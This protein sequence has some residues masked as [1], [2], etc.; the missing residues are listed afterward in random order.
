MKLEWKGWSPSGSL[1]W[2]QGDCDNDSH[3]EGDLKCFHDTVPPGCSGTAASN[4]ADY[5][6]S[7]QIRI[8]SSSVEFGPDIPPDTDIPTALSNPDMS[9]DWSEWFRY[10]HDEILSILCFFVI[11]LCGLNLCVLMAKRKK[12]HY[13]LVK[14]V[15]SAEESDL[16]TEA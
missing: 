10:F 12:R 6:G 16:E 1:G 15:E 13:I 7:D 14:F 8:V 5:C 2:C 3:C 11:V 9:V 4:S